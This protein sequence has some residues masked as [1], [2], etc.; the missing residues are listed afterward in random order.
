MRQSLQIDRVVWEYACLRPS[1]VSYDVIVIDPALISND[2]DLSISKSDAE[3]PALAGTGLTYT[4]TVSNA[5]PAAA[6]NVTVNDTLPGGVTFSSTSGCTNDPNGLP[7]C[8]LGTIAENASKSYQ[9]TVAV[10][11]STSGTI[12]N[13]VTVSTTTNDPVGGNDSDSENTQID[14]P[15]SCSTGTIN[16]G[17]GDSTGNATF[18]TE[19]SITAGSGFQ[20]QSGGTVHLRARTTITL[21]NGFS[22]AD[23][24]NFRAVIDPLVNCP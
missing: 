6:E 3:D 10:G 14:A 24:T 13:S 22:T 7:S 12:T 4:V 17:T 9:V 1:S 16:L 21:T 8:S 11:T 15:P 20:V 2:A 23:G 19:N 5:G 18:L